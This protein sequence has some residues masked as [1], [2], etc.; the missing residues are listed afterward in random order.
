MKRKTL[1][2]QAGDY[3][4]YTNGTGISP[5]RGHIVKAH[6]RSGSTGTYEIKPSDG[7]RKVTRKAIHVS[8][9]KE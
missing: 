7:H 3:A 1:P 6:P 4:E 2:Y 5:S 9:A 8:K